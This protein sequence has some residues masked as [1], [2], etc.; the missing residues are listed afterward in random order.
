MVQDPELLLGLPEALSCRLCSCCGRPDQAR[1]AMQGFPAQW[2]HSTRQQKELEDTI[3]DDCAKCLPDLPSM[4]S[5][6][7]MVSTTAVHHSESGGALPC[8][9]CSQLVFRLW[10]LDWES[11]AWTV[12]QQLA[13]SR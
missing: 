2:I 12:L 13:G 3:W 8:M 6:T 4:S 9:S 11:M 1:A 5:S 7:M 10:V